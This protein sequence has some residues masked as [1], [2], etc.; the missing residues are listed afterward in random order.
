MGDTIRLPY[1]LVKPWS[2][3]HRC[4]SAL[5]TSTFP[6]LLVHGPLEPPVFAFFTWLS[7][8][9]ALGTFG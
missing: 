8:T 2:Y 3:D 1:C 6:N 9:T 5:F 4:R 7:T